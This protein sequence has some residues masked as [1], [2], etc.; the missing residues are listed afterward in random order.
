MRVNRACEL[1]DA[2][3]YPLT[4]DEVAHQVGDNEVEHPEGTETVR[5]VLARFEPDTFGCP[6]E[7]RLMFLSALGS[8]A[9][10]RKGYTDRDPPTWPAESPD[11]PSF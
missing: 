10:G 3:A 5:E 4:S 2:L 11:P 7:A 8:E 6:E 9:I 1:F